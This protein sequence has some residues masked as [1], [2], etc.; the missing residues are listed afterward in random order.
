MKHEWHRLSELMPNETA[1]YFVCKR[2]GTVQNE[3][4]RDKPCKGRVKMRPDKDWNK[5]APE[6]PET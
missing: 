2:C 4:N 5:H 3:S 1:S 6:K